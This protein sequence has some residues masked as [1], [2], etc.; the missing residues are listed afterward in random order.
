M[1]RDAITLADVRKP[2]IGLLS[3]RRAGGAAR[4][5]VERLIA[6]HGDAKLTDPEGVLGQLPPPITGLLLRHARPLG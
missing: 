3:A 5:N 2:T 6:E 4:Y 1:P